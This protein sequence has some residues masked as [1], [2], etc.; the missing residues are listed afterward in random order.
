MRGVGV[1]YEEDIFVKLMHW[2]LLGAE[3]PTVEQQCMALLSHN[4][5]KLIH[6]PARDTG[7]LVF[8][9]LACQSL[10]KKGAKNLIL[11]IPHLLYT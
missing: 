10:K 9:L 6:Y 1:C 4:R 7:K 5:D 3:I 8:R 2:D 11:I